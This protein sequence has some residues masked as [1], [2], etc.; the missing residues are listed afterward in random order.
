MPAILPFFT[1]FTAVFSTKNH[2]SG[3]KIRYKSLF[4]FGNRPTPSLL[5]AFGI[6]AAF[7]LLAL[8]AVAHS[9]KTGDVRIGHPWSKPTADGATT[10][11]VYMSFLNQGMKDD[12]MRSVSTSIARKAVLVDDKGAETPFLDLPLNH[13]VALR[14]GAAH[15]RLDDLRGGL[16]TGDHFTLRLTFANAPPVDVIA[17]VQDSPTEMNGM[18]PMEMK[19]AK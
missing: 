9:F 6:M 19:P 5:L 14:P 1:H 2:V 4:S 16:S 13:G 3:R 7:A 8:P 12:Q 17:Y 10:G 15:V 11:E 18:P